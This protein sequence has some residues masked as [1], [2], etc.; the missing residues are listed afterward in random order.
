LSKISSFVL[1]GGLLAS[2]Q[3]KIPD[4]SRRAE[5]LLTSCRARAE[6]SIDSEENPKILD[7][8]LAYHSWSDGQ[9][10]EWIFFSPLGNRIGRLFLSETEESFWQSP[11][12]KES[13]EKAQVPYIEWAYSRW[14]ESAQILLGL[15][16]RP[17]AHNIS[18]IENPSDTLRRSCRY[19][20]SAHRLQVDFSFLSC[21]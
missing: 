1:L 12:G 6:V 4:G 2:C 8:T 19:E 14:Q 10:L 20:S 15:R 5:A 21:E 7:S 9:E 18:C 13:L 16:S 11:Q 17:G 3:A